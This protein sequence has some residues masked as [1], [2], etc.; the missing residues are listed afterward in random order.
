MMLYEPST[1]TFGVK[2]VNILIH[3]I[4]FQL[5]S[6]LIVFFPHNL[7]PSICFL[8]SGSDL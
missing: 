4:N 5:F 7:A 2:N 3:L 6:K 8:H 1:V